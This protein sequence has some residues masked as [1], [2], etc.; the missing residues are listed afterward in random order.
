MIFKFKEAWS[1]TSTRVCVYDY[2]IGGGGRRGF[3]VRASSWK[4]IKDRVAGENISH[5][6][7]KLL[8]SCDETLFLSRANLNTAGYQLNCCFSLSPFLPVCT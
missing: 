6:I 4:V 3:S 8:F 2:Y 5:A 7:I 1:V